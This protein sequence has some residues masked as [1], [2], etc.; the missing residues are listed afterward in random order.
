MPNLLSLAFDFK[1][2]PTPPAARTYYEADV[3]ANDA[4]I[5]DS[6]SS[7]AAAWSRVLDVTGGRR[8]IPNFHYRPMRPPSRA[9]YQDVIAAF[10][11]IDEELPQSLGRAFTNLKINDQKTTLDLPVTGLSRELFKNEDFEL[12]CTYAFK[13]RTDQCSIILT[14]HKLPR[15]P[16]RASAEDLG[17]ILS[18]LPLEYLRVGCRNIDSKVLFGMPPVA[19]D[20]KT[21]DVAFTDANP[22][23]VVIFLRIAHRRCKTL[24][25]LN[26]AVSPLHDRDPHDQ[27]TKKAFERNDVSSEIANKWRPFWNRLD[28]IAA[29]GVIVWEGEVRPKHDGRYL[30]FRCSRVRL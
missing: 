27:I 14:Y 10:I 20:L 5:I 8:R 4:A 24:R 21:L 7:S 9:H 6:L 28:D 11:A 30:D 26:I 3:L 13:D 25:K 19:E 16:I 22:G 12:A 15:V 29:S 17:F 2:D 1:H 23:Q 18:G